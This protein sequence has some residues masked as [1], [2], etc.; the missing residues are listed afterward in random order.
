M[1]ENVC[2]NSFKN[3]KNF[4]LV[5]IEEEIHKYQTI[6][7]QACLN[8]FDQC[9]VE[10]YCVRKKRKKKHQKCAR[11]RVGTAKKLH[12][13]SKFP[14]EMVQLIWVQPGCFVFRVHIIFLQSTNF[15]ILR[16]H[17]STE[18]LSRSVVSTQQSKGDQML[19]KFEKKTV[20]SEFCSI[21]VD[22]VNKVYQIVRKRITQW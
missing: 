22:S 20:Q 13:L 6:F 19:S 5:Q 21:G 16:M 9:L 10:L 12:N 4:V 17:D 14:L 15:R 8:L 3:F 2:F 7:L 11:V 1:V 18:K